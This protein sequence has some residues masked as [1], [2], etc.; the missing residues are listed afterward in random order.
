VCD[1]KKASGWREAA[2]S[3]VTRDGCAGRIGG[4]RQ[5]LPA[6]HERLWIDL[7]VCGAASHLEVEVHQVQQPDSPRRILAAT[8][9]ALTATARR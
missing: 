1:R 3:S 2:R 4:I 5:K 9:V 6:R 8:A 7:I